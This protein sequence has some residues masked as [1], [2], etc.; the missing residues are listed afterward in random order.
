MRKIFRNAYSGFIALRMHCFFGSKMTHLTRQPSIFLEKLYSH[1]FWPLLSR[2][3]EKTFL[4]DPVLWSH[5]FWAQNG[6]FAKNDFFFFRKT[7]NITSMYYLQLATGQNFKKTVRVDPGLW[8]CI[9]FGPKMA[10][11]LQREF[12]QKIHQ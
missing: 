7:I 2:W 8:G 11:L 10:H 9:I 12:F 4:V 5:Y 1:T 6:P 3:I